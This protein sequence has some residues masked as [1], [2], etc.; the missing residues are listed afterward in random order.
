MSTIAPSL[1]A[2]LVALQALTPPS[3]ASQ[4]AAALAPPPPALTGASRT[5]LAPSAA[6]AVLSLNTIV[7]KAPATATAV[8]GDAYAREAIPAEKVHWL[9]SLGA[10]A[11]SPRRPASLDDTA[12]EQRA[13]ARMSRSG[14][15]KL[16]GFAEARENGTLKVQRA[17]AM[18]D[19]GYRSYQLTLYREGAEFGGVAFSTI[20]NDRWM[21]LRQSGT[22]AA[23]GSVDGNDYVATWPLAWNGATEQQ[24]A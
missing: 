16:P 9:E 2:G 10:D 17:S 12:F 4:Q 6:D 13:L 3:P 24:A 18:P 23:T 14:T 11:W 21:A 8:V 22:F 19:L 7:P 1:S 15:S 5:M 20:N